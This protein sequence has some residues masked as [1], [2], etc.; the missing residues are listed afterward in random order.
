MLLVMIM[1]VLMMSLIMILMMTKM[2][3]KGIISDDSSVLIYHNI[4]KRWILY[5]RCSRSWQ[6]P[7]SIVSTLPPSAGIIIIHQNCFRRQCRSEYDVGWP[8]RDD[9]AVPEKNELTRLSEVFRF[10]SLLSC[11]TLHIVLY[12]SGIVHC[13]TISLWVWK[14]R[15]DCRHRNPNT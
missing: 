2:R 5:H 3:G 10:S 12:F 8:S 4:P 15:I 14:Y 11:R 13:C 7:R 1:V 9:V 6:A